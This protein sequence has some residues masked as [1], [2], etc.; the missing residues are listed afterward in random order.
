MAST[1]L[2]IGT[3]VPEHVLTPAARRALLETVWPRLKLMKPTAEEGGG[4]RH[5]VVPPDRLLERRG[6]TDSMRS[7]GVAATQLAEEAAPNARVMIQDYHLFLAPRML[8]TLRPDLR[9]GHFTHT[10]WAAPD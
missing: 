6:L 8:R 3:A 5:L 9:T 2:A 1:I 4:D 7:Y 10:P